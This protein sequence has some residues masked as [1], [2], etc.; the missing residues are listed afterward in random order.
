[1]KKGNF[2]SIILP[3]MGL[4]SACVLLIALLVANNKAYPLIFIGLLGFAVNGANLYL[5]IF[6]NKK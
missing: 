6:K 2:I 4:F 5:G 3:S 1:M